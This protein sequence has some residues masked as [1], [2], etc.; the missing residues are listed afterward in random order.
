MKRLQNGVLIY[1][2]VILS[3]LKHT[4]THRIYAHI[5]CADDMTHLITPKTS[6]P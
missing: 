3:L 6:V 5:T 2:H 1:F 4:H